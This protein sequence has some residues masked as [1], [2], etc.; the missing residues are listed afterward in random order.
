MTA[1]M[2]TSLPVPEGTTAAAPVVVVGGGPIG[3]RFVR[4]L[5]RRAPTQPVVLYDSEPFAPYNRV[6]L[7]A[8]LAGEI[9]VEQLVDSDSLAGGPTELRLHCGVVDIDAASKKV[10]D[11]R[12]RETTYSTLVLAT[13]SRPRVPDIP[14]IG[15][16][17]VFV[18]RTLFDAQRLQARMASSRRIV[19]IGGG[20]LGLESARAMQRMGDRVIVVDHNPRLMMNQL[21]DGAAERLQQHIA[22]LGIEVLLN[23]PVARLH[24]EGKVTGV[25][26]RSGALLPCDTVL[27]AAGIVPSTELAVLAGLR[28]RRGVQVDDHMRSSDPSIYAIGE[29]SEHRDRTYGV[30]APGLEQAAVAAHAISGGP[31]TNYIGSVVAS[32]LKVLDLPVFSVGRVTER[33]RLER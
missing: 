5:R 14:G 13:G 2:A 12:G 3:V 1:S 19:V 20:L 21:D 10:I 6:Q 4:E 16:R 15:Q 7:T 11:A 9:S 31:V 26:L 22:D 27:L 8:F 17:N 33:D 25:R 23:E 30:V 32:R 24:G 29:C 18:F 28:I